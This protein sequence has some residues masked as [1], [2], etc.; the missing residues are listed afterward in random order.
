[1]N[2]KIDFTNVNMSKITNR[3]CCAEQKEGTLFNKII[4]LSVAS[5]WLFNYKKY[6]D[7]KQTA[8]R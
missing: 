3:L 4:W 2:Q 6:F 5:H 8:D 7:L 1:M